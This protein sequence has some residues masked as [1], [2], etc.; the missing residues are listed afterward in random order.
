MDGFS[1]LNQNGEATMVDVGEKI[2]TDR[3]AKA[4]AK[5]KVAL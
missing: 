2:V 3:T 4:F 1:H 5:L